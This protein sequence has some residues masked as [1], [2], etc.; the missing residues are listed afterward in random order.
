MVRTIAAV[1][2]IALSASLLVGPAQAA[3]SP[4]HFVA[5]GSMAVAREAAVATLNSDGT[6]IVF[7]GRNGDTIADSTSI[8]DPATGTFRAGPT[9]EVPRV[10]AV[11]AGLP[12]GTT[13]I[14][15]G[16]TG[17]GLTA[18][19]QTYNPATDSLTTTGSL[20]TAINSPLG[21][22]LGDGRVLV[23]G[24]ANGPGAV[25]TS[26]TYSLGEG[27]AGGFTVTYQLNVARVSAATTRLANGDVLIAGGRNNDGVLKSAELFS[28]FGATY[29]AVGAMNTPRRDAGS[30][31]LPDGRVLIVGG[32]DGAGAVAST[33]LYDPAT[34]SFTPGP[35]LARARTLANVIPLPDGRVLVAGGTSGSGGI[36][37]SGLDSTE[38]YDPT[39]DAFSPGPQMTA[40]RGNATA[41]ILDDGRV[42]IVGGT[43]AQGSALSSAE[44]FTPKSTTPSPAPVPPQPAVVPVPAVAI[45]CSALPAKIKR[46]GKTTLL[47]A[48][49]ATSGGAA[50]TTTVTRLGKKRGS[51]AVTRSAS[52]KVAITT[53]KA[54][55]LRLKITRAA[56]ATPGYT[57]YQSSQ[58]YRIR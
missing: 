16:D 37:S 24:G 50:I 47:A 51:F 13:L 4:D 17:S 58:T 38:I 14:A 15:A 57:S 36:S 44:I 18:S 40:A 35:P 28:R 32:A 6:V 12:N 42:L 19:A 8:Y 3:P 48:A 46:S 41:T 33:E 49:C 53:K 7:G 23:A 54:K 55:G 9:M 31:L 34:G 2:C 27:I 1:V 21:I 20:D 10:G 11:A 25:R 26:Q 56:A 30:A 52:G 22:A 29:E 43:D 5:T 45:G 39:A